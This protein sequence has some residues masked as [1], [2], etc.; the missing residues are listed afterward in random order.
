MLSSG[1]YF[2]VKEELLEALLQG[3]EMIMSLRKIFLEYGGRCSGTPR[4]IELI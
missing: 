1:L 3:R 4:E 2:I